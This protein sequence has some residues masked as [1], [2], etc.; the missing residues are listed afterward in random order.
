[1]CVSITFFKKIELNKFLDFKSIYYIDLTN[2]VPYFDL[3]VILFIIPFKWYFLAPLI[4]LNFI[5]GV[6]RTLHPL[7]KTVEN[8]CKVCPSPGIWAIAF[9][10][11][12]NN[13][14]VNF[15]S[16]EFGFLGVLTKTLIQVPPFCGALLKANNFF[17]FSLFF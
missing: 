11:V 8:F 17:F 7:H 14:F 13:I 9:F 3:P 15:L 10:L 1:M 4:T 6:S 12:V 16:A 5:P 2:F